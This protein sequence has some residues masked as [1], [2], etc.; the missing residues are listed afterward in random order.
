MLRLGGEPL[1]EQRARRATALLPRSPV[2]L[3]VAFL[4]LFAA[5]LPRLIERIYWD[6][7]AATAAVIAQTVG[8]GTVVLE[9]YGWFTALRLALL[10]RPLPFHRELWEIAPYLFSLVSVTLLTWASWRLA[11]RFAA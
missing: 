9:R 4:V 5:R 8:H 2:L 11:G 3:G 10:T 1:L 6:S 7:D